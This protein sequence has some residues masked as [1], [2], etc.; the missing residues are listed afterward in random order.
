MRR[1]T[2]WSRGRRENS[3]ATRIQAM[4]PASLHPRPHYGSYGWS[5]GVL[6]RRFLAGDLELPATLWFQP[7]PEYGLSKNRPGQRSYIVSASRMRG[8]SPTAIASRRST[9]EGLSAGPRSV[10]TAAVGQQACAA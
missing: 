4:T 9:A 5:A 10:S 7:R 1:D 8:F 2:P 3:G 6:G